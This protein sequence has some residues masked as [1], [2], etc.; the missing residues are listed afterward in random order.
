MDNCFIHPSSITVLYAQTYTIDRYTLFSGWNCIDFRFASFTRRPILSSVYLRN[1]YI[2]RFSWSFCLSNNSF[3]SVCAK[4]ERRRMGQTTRA[5]R[6]VSVCSKI[7]WIR[8]L[9]LMISFSLSDVPGGLSIAFIIDPRRSIFS[10]F[11]WWKIEMRRY[12]RN[13]VDSLIST[14]GIA[15]LSKS[16]GILV[17]FGA[18]DIW[19]LR[20][21]NGLNR[22]S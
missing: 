19:R 4:R 5:F 21:A 12:K 17:F 18:G 20:R 1:R 14:T 22:F 15:Q 11:I 3:C 2:S 9:L 6:S 7:Q 13:D 8:H 16:N 10:R